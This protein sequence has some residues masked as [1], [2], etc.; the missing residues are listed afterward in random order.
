MDNLIIFA[1]KYLIL[2]PLLALVYLAIKLNHK[3]RLEL[4]ALFVLGGLMCL[5]F[6]KFASHF[7]SDPRPLFADHV[8]PLITSPRDNG[9]P[10]DHTLLSAFSAFL[11]FVFSKRLGLILLVVAL[12]IGIGRVAAG[13]HHAP[14]VAGGIIFA[15]ISVMGASLVFKTYRNLTAGHQSV[16]KD[17]P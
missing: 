15:G 9:F 16:A 14:D 2:L 12:I 4:L 17:K 10:S 8:T 11:V 6:S 5:L 7:Y 3:K 1:A 13:V